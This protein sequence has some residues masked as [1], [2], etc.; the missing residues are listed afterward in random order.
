VL[1]IRR[2]NSIPRR[3]DSLYRPDGHFLSARWLR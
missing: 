2:A 1:H 3:Q